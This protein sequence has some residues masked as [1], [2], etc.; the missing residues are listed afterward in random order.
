MWEEEQQDGENLGAG[1]NVDATRYEPVTPASSGLNVNATE[2][3]FNGTVAQVAAYEAYED[4]M[5]LHHKQRLHCHPTFTSTHVRVAELNEVERS[6]IMG[7]HIFQVF[8]LFLGANASNLHLLSHVQ[9]KAG[10]RWATSQ[11]HP[12]LIRST[13]SIF[14]D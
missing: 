8:R 7:D 14:R 4:D 2:Y 1:L 10:L 12:T 5:Q 3:S 13:S 6:R 9:V 11:Q